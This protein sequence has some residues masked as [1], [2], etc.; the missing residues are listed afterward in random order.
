MSNAWTVSFS[1]AVRLLAGERVLYFKPMVWAASGK[2]L[3]NYRLSLSLPLV[4]EMGLYV[5]DRR[6]VLAC[7]LF[8]LV[9]CE[10]TA[11]LRGGDAAADEDRVKTVAVGRNALLGPYLELIASNPVHHWWRSREARLRL[12]MKNPEA[13]NRLL[14]EVLGPTTRGEQGGPAHGSQ[15]VGEGTKGTSEG[16]GSRA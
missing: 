4:Q 12:F 14:S 16:A 6:V 5:T 11:W 7:W 15:P 2:S 1:L 9:R 8:R 10:W 13:L 3:P